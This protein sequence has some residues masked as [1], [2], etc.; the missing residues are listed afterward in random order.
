M[1]PCASLVCLC[2]AA[3]AFVSSSAMTLKRQQVFIRHDNS[4]YV[5][6]YTFIYAEMALTDACPHKVSFKIGDK[7][8]PAGRVLK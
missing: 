4:N 7:R 2:R 5:I 8:R 3:L 6:S 1:A